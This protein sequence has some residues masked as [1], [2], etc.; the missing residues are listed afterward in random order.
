[1]ATRNN[2]YQFPEL[3]MPAAA[4]P[5]P[6]PRVSHFA[7]AQG[8]NPASPFT[9]QWSNPSD[10]TAND[11]V[12]VFIVD[13][14]ESIVFSTPYPPTSYPACLRGTNTSVVVPADTLQGDLAYSG[15]IVFFRVTGMNTTAYPGATGLTLIGAS[16]AFPMAAPSAMAPVL[17]QPTMISSTQ[18]GFLLS[19]TAGQDYT[20]LTATN[21]AL[22]L[23][24]WS[25]L[26]TT[27]L[28]G[29]SAFILDNQATNKQRLYRAK[30]GL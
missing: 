26:L 11:L 28:S 6:P 25:T 3:A 17:S 30:Q 24:N 22:P 5:S 8:I 20:V 23:S 18:F 27:N 13:R 7:A 2:G 4:Y 14:D 12:W 10:A 29:N 15:V 19:G 16:T 21:P 1:M 9:L